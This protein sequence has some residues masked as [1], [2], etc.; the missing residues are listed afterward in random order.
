MTGVAVLFARR[1]SVYKSIPGLDVYDADRNAMNFSGACGVVAHPPC[2]GWGRL[3]VFARPAPWEFVTGL[4]AVQAVRNFGGVLE[5]PEHSKLWAAPG[6]AVL[7]F[8]GAGRDAWGGW[9][10]PVDQWWWGHKARKRTWLYIVGVSPADLPGIPYRIGEADYVVGSTR[11]RKKLP[12]ISK[13]DR[14]RT[15][16]ELAQWLVDVAGAAG[17]GLGV[18]A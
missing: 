12:E 15:P 4:F 7:P 2:R 5:H 16:P 3:S 18:A 13:A 10:L 6:M 1:D 11:G 17:S 14:E 8:P 9:T